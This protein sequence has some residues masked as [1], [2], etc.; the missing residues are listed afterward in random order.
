MP[1]VEVGVAAGLAV[2]NPSSGDGAPEATH[3]PNGAP[4]PL[5]V[6]QRRLR[7]V[8]ADANGWIPLGS[9]SIGRVWEVRKLWVIKTDPWTADTNLAAIFVGDPVTGQ[10][11]LGDLEVPSLT[12]PWIFTDSRNAIVVPATQ[13][14]YIVVNGGSKANIAG[15][16]VIEYDADQYA[17]RYRPGK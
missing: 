13:Q 9:P 8:Q 1:E 11:Q 10:V 3:K 17:Q 4:S 15:G 5:L 14:V 12:V 7:P 16:A 6:V 2:G